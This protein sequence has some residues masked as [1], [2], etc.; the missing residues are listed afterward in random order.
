MR[1]NGQSSSKYFKLFQDYVCWL[2]NKLQDFEIN[3][4]VISGF[5]KEQL[6]VSNIKK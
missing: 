2:E 4:G 6:I 5:L 1:S 3:T